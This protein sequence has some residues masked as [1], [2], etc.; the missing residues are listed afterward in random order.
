MSIFKLTGTK[1]PQVIELSADATS[2]GKTTAAWRI[3]HYCDQRGIKTILVTIESRGITVGRALRPG[4]VVI[5]TEDF[6][7][8][9]ELPG[10]LAGVLR[11]LSTAIERAART[12]AAVVIDWAGGH[13]Q[14]RL[15][16]LAAMCFDQILAEFDLVGISVIVTT[17]ATDKMRQASLNL[18]T[19]REVVPGL[20][21]ALLLNERGGR[22]DFIPGSAPAVAYQELLRAA[23][24][25][26]AIRFP[27]IEGES[28][29]ACEQAGLTMPAV[30]RATPAQLAA[31]LR[32][33]R[34]T[35]AAI[36]SEVT[37][38]WTLTERS[39]ASVFPFRAEQG[40]E[41]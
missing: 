36:I 26:K 34:F 3:R 22:F 20:Q 29:Q 8:A 9:K 13:A 6:R 10:G 2:V 27:A 4:D 12:G 14:D 31:K 40:A 39:L 18:T 41:V 23:Q 32:L 1:L 11:P 37:A 28:W 15:E 5:A 19:T 38:W 21:R 16:A 30:I 33:D 35:T 7:R 25:V 24:G 17:C